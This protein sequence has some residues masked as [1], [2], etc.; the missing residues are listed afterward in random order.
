[1]AL[2]GGEQH[3]TTLLC[4]AS[5]ASLTAAQLRQYKHLT[6]SAAAEPKAAHLQVGGN[7]YIA[8][9]PHGA[10]EA[11]GDCD[12]TEVSEWGVL[13]QTHVSPRRWRCTTCD[14]NVCGCPHLAVA[15]RAELLQQPTD[16]PA[17]RSYE[18]VSRP[19]I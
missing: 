7:E 9:W 16:G 12:A 10:V 6:T 15:E 2:S 4:S 8:A 14:R 11:S 3:F 13:R 5:G 18:A 19:L 1:M 17:D